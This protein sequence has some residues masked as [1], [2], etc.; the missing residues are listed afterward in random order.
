M[1]ALIYRLNVGSATDGGV[2][3]L[4]DTRDIFVGFS[5][6]Q[7]LLTN[8][9]G[10][11]NTGSFLSFNSRAYTLNFTQ[12]NLTTTQYGDATLD[13]TSSENLVT[14]TNSTFLSSSYQSYGAIRAYQSANLYINDTTFSECKGNQSSAMLLNMTSTNVTLGN[15]TFSQCQSHPSS[16]YSQQTTVWIL[17]SSANL[18]KLTFSGN[19]GTTGAGLMIQTQSNVSLNSTT[20]DANIATGSGGGIYIDGNS[21]LVLKDVTATNNEAVFYGGFIWGLSCYLNFSSTTIS[22]N[23]AQRGGGFLLFGSKTYA[24]SSTVNNNTAQVGAAFYVES[25]LLHLGST[26]IGSN[27]LG[28]SSTATNQHVVYIDEANFTYHDSTFSNNIANAGSSGIYAVASYVTIADVIFTSDDSRDVN[29]IPNVLGGFLMTF[30]TDVQVYRGSFSRGKASRGGAI[31]FGYA[32][33]AY[34]SL[35]NFDSNTAVIGGG[36]Y[37]SQA[38]DITVDSTQFIVNHAR[39]GA[40]IGL[41]D[42]INTTASNCG[43]T[44]GANQT[45]IYGAWTNL[46]IDSDTFSDQSASQD[47][48]ADNPDTRQGIWCDGCNNT[49]VINTTF[50]QLRAVQGAAF[51]VKN[52]QL[53]F[54]NTWISKSRFNGGRA[55]QGGGVYVS[56]RTNTT[57]V[58]STFTGNKV[59]TYAGTNGEGACVY[60]DCTQ[61]IEGCIMDIT[62]T[63]FTDNY[64]ELEGGAIKWTSKPYKNSTT[65]TFTGNLALYGN[66]EAS[67]PVKF[68]LLTAGNITYLP[69]LAVDPMNYDPTTN[70]T[71]QFNLS[72]IPSG[73][74]AGASRNT[75]DTILYGLFDHYGQRVLS[76]NFSQSSVV[77][78]TKLTNDEE[79]APFYLLGSEVKAVQGLFNFSRLQIVS[80]PGI[81]VRVGATTDAFDWLSLLIREAATRRLEEKFGE[82][83]LPEEVQAR[84]LSAYDVQNSQIDIDLRLCVPGEIQ[85]LDY[86]CYE[87]PNNEYWIEDVNGTQTCEK[88]V[89]E[90]QCF[91]SNF[92]GP[93]PGYWRWHRNSSNFLACPGGTETCL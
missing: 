79:D 31:Y 50:N 35:T 44:L 84:L 90:A 41:Q 47:F 75:Y 83:T 63:S 56:G 58:D 40:D 82:N 74:I 18:S 87:C 24:T 21:I 61:T 53:D 70:P 49:Y 26:N 25:G 6:V 67:Y 10:T 13:I 36:I 73:Q 15:L 43:F 72:N 93:L 23:T 51:F 1:S 16:T 9:T 62:T 71:T 11:N 34:L 32:T 48:F 92:W 14:I 81:Q 60:Y 64:A 5:N 80:K 86:Q 19:Q 66:D 89:A 65:N 33:T 39:Y 76:N 27:N 2:F 12:V 69:E 7:L 22:G 29:Y 57:I 38:Q 55:A 46:T 54:V 37:V 20:F 42:A 85:T 59:S 78:I 28:I 45:S 88:C 91:G 3:C 30:E 4:I 8:L 17:Q 68:N 77:P 52:T